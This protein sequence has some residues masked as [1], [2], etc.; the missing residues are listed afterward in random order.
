[1]QVSDRRR[2][3]STFDKIIVILDRDIG[4]L[5]PRL[6]RDDSYF[7]DFQ[8]RECCLSSLTGRSGSS[9]QGRGSRKENKQYQGLDP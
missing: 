8:Y 6:R 7:F 4:D 1:M 5:D 3:R 2:L 9:A